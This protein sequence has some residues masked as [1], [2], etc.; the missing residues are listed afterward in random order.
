MDRRTVLS[1]SNVPRQSSLLQNQRLQGEWLEGT[2][3]KE[4]LQ[5][6][7]KKDDVFG[8]ERILK[9]RKHKKVVE[10]L[11]KWFGYPALFDFWVNEKDLV[12]LLYPTLT[13]F[14]LLLKLWSFVVSISLYNLTQSNN[15]KEL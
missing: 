12:C 10:F 15:N 3:Y 7:Y 9:Q 14:C 8:V 2:F 5:K 13:S 4:E 11:I 1:R 6:I